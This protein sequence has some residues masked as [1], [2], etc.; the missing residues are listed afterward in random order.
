MLMQ[1]LNKIRD[2]KVQVLFH[3][4][5]LLTLFIQLH[6]E[7]RLIFIYGV[8]EILKFNFDIEQQNEWTKTGPI[9][10]YWKWLNSNMLL[11][12]MNKHQGETLGSQQLQ[13]I[14]QIK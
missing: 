10:N 5:F 8:C 11:K 14:I 4:I 13:Q 6:F 12:L 7:S 1:K 3:I 2:W 9:F